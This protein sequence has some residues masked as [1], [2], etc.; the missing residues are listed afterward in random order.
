MGEKLRV[1]QKIR[2]GTGDFV[3]LDNVSVYFQIRKG[4]LKRIFVVRALENI[5][6][7]IGEH[8]VLVI[9]GESGCGKSTL[10]RV[11]AGLQPPSHGRL[12]FRGKDVRSLKGRE[13][14]E[15]RRSIQLVHQ[16]PYSSLN[17]TKTVFDIL[18]SPLKYWGYVKNKDEALEKILELL[19]SVKVTPPEEYIFRYPHQLS[20]GEKQRI[21][22]ARALSVKPRFIVADEVISA[23]DVSLRIDLMNLMIDFWRKY[24]IGYLFITH[25]LASARYFAELTGGIIAVMYLGRVVEA[26]PP[27][28]LIFNPLHPYTKALIAATPELLMDLSELRKKKPLPLKSVDIPSATKYIPGCKFNT[29]CP[30]ADR[31]CLDEEPMLREVEPGHYVACHKVL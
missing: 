18:Y 20:G 6:I 23:I 3:E 5:N 25:E 27:R 7:A 13:Y 22:L 21:A 24:G 4:L 28:K 12:L 10:G 30:F 19:E 14:R 26:A 11:V 29:R 31:R 1:T 9:V 2:V 15:F 8:S 16:D 17:P